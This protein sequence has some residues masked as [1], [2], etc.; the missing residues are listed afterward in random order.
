MLSSLPIMALKEIPMGLAA[1]LDETT[2]LLPEK[3]QVKCLPVKSR[4]LQVNPDFSNYFALT[5]KAPSDFSLFA[6]LR[7]QRAL[8]KITQRILEFWPHHQRS[9]LL[10][11]VPFTDNH[12]RAYRD[13]D[14]KGIGYLRPYN[15]C[16]AVGPKS[17]YTKVRVV[18]P[19]GLKEGTRERLGLLHEQDA[20][21]DYLTS[22]RFLDVGIRTHRVM[23]LM[24]LEEVDYEGEKISVLEARK[25]DLLD[26]AYCPV[27]AVRAF[28]TRARVCDL[29]TDIYKQT[30]IQDAITLVSQELGVEEILTGREYLMWFARTLGKNVG[31]MH[32]H[33][34]RHNYLNQHNVTLDCRIVDHDGV[35]ESRDWNKGFKDLNGASEALSRLVAIFSCDDFPLDRQREYHDY[36][37]ENYRLNSL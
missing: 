2:R 23:A 32:K 5:Q 25:R 16:L 8:E 11:R 14:L 7:K 4:V 29:D 18:G 35:T 26:D 19:G 30:V 13:V 9:A 27:I 15:D 22:E 34:W 1:R 12:G 37:I 21:N 17:F 10:E 31:L 28:G 24:A 20:G 3:Y 6:T 36:F 33:D